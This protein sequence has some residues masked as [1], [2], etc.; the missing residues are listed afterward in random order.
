MAFQYQFRNGAWRIWNDELV[1]PTKKR[2]K[3]G[4]IIYYRKAVDYTEVKSYWLYE[5][6]GDCYELSRYYNESNNKVLVATNLHWTI[7][8]IAHQIKD[9]MWRAPVERERTSVIGPKVQHSDYVLNW[10]KELDGKSVLILSTV[11]PKMTM[12]EIMMVLENE[13]ASVDAQGIIH[14][15]K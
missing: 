6:V 5:K 11:Y 1:L 7:D 4:S 8:A 3:D 2:K 13:G 14:A 15:K 12:R 9:K 10:S